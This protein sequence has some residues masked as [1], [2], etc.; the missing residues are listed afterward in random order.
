MGASRTLSASDA[1]DPGYSANPSASTGR[2]ALAVA[3]T[4]WRR[5][6][7]VVAHVSRAHASLCVACRVPMVFSCTLRRQAWEDTSTKRT[8]MLPRVAFE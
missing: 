7:A 1:W 8:A 3:P 6:V 4:A 2:S 5:S